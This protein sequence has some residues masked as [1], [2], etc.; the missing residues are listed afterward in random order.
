MITALGPDLEADGSL[1]R[2]VALDRV[3]SVPDGLGVRECATLDV[4]D[5]SRG[6]R[7]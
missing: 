1:D 4:G 2:G 3:R 7:V 6:A 5:C